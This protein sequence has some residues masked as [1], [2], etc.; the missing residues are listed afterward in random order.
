MWKQKDQ[1]RNAEKIINIQKEL[2]GRETSI[3]LDSLRATLRKV[4]NW[5]TSG[6][7]GI[8]KVLL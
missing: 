2:Q 6:H 3:Y 1:N 5:K 4:L 8:H 7:D